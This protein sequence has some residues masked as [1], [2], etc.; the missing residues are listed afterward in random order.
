MVRFLTLRT[1]FEKNMMRQYLYFT[2][3][4]L[5]CL[6]SCNLEK[7]VQVDLPE[8]ESQLVVECYLEVGQPYRLALSESVSYFA[9]PQLPIINNATV[10]ISDGLHSDTLLNTFVID[11]LSEKIYNFVHPRI[12][13]EDY[14]KV[15]TLSVSLDDGQQISATTSFLEPILIDS[16]VPIFNEDNSFASVF[17]YLTDPPNEDNFFRR[18]FHSGQNIYDGIL[19]QDFSTTDA[20][21]NSN[22]QI[23]FGSGF[24]FTEG[25]TLISTLFHMDEDY[26]NFMES[27]DDAIGSNGNPFAQPGAVLSNIEGG[28]GIFTA[29]SYDRKRLIIE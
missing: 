25:D 26:Y 2:L 10:V 7:D 13:E 27:Y 20:L 23:I 16:L 22:G 17:T 1:F 19:E 8:Y 11:T 14:D 12:V 15:Y 6:F 3:L 18:V 4:L 5:A 24:S 9:D 29:H 28:I 21:V